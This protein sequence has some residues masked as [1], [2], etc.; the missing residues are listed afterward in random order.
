M[1]STD[2]VEWTPLTIT[3]V[4]YP[5]GDLVGKFLALLSLTPFGVLIGFVTLILFRRDLHTVTFFVGLILNEMINMT[6]KYIIQ[7]PRPAR[8]HI[9]KVSVPYGMPSSHAQFMWFFSTYILCFVVVRLRYNNSTYKYE[10]YWKG[11]IVLSSLLLTCIVSYSRIY[12][13][14]HTWNQILYGAIIGS[15]LGTGWFIVTQLF[16]SPL[17]PLITQW[18]I[19]EML[20]I[21]DTTLIP[22]ILWFEYTHCRQ[23]TRARSRKLVSMKSQ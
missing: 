6:L 5:K 2:S 23:E 8:D 9:D 14:Y 4:E 22:N 7:E 18:R 10:S 1:D 20:M 13:L 17:F 3:Y 19:S 21:R 15:I 16:L 12:L 11:F